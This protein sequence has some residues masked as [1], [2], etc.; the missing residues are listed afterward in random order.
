MSASA[1]ASTTSTR[2]LTPQVFTETPNRR[3]ASTLS[4]SVT[5][6]LRMLSPNRASLRPVIS[7]RPSAARAQTP[8]LRATSGSSTWP[9]TVLRVT[10][11]RVWTAAN[12]RSPCAAWLRFMKSM[13]ISDHGSA[14][15]ACV[16]RWSSGLRSASRPVIHIFAGLNVCIH[17]ITPTHR[18]S[19]VASSSARRIAS[20]SVSTGFVTTRAGRC[21][22]ASRAAAIR[23]EWSATWSRTS[24]P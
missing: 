8:T 10:P 20:A 16:C 1:T 14:W 22:E 4:P 24:G 3:S 13:S 12:S 5:A 7:A 15:L 21:G 17:A 9:V 6:T 23:A 2:S 18:S 19:A 11:I